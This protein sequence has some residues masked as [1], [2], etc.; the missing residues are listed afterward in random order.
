MM[1]DEHLIEAK[2][3]LDACDGFFLVTVTIGEGEGS[4]LIS[5]PGFD[6]AEQL[7]EFKAA[8]ARGVEMLDLVRQTTF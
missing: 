3:Q 1:D 7:P 4:G 5:L 2:K 8:V 6:S